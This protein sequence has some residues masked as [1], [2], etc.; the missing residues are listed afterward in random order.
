MEEQVKK[1]KED[2][3]IDIILQ[4]NTFNRELIKKVVNREITPQQ[5]KEQCNKRYS[6]WH[7]RLKSSSSGM[8]VLK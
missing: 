5:F 1:E 8:P 4:Q 7:G 2:L 6:F 3:S